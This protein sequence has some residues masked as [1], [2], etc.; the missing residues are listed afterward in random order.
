ML[1]LAAFAALLP[2]LAAAH[3][4]PDG[5][6]HPHGSEGLILV[7]VVGLALLALRQMRR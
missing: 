6:G 2:A 4:G 7:A 3:G 5:H 1:K